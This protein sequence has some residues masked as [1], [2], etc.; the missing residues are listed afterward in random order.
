[1]QKVSVNFKFLSSKVFVVQILMNKMKFSSH[2]KADSLFFP[3]LYHKLFVVN[4]LNL[5][6]N[7]VPSTVSKSIFFF[8]VFLLAQRKRRKRKLWKIC[9][10]K[11]ITSYIGTVSG[12]SVPQC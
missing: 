10:L 6:T 8:F 3:P 4:K 12:D 5:F 2:T 1:M 7:K 11:Q 9:E